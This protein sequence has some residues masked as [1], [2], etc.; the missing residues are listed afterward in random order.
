MGVLLWLFS[1][2]VISLWIFSL[3]CYIW[4]VILRVFAWDAFILFSLVCV[5]LRVF[6]SGCSLACVIIGVVLVCLSSLW[7]SLC[8]CSLILVVLLCVLSWDVIFVG[9]LFMVFSC[10]CYRCGCSL[11]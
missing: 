2:W 5:I 9:V 6:Y 3:W 8:G 4:G 1:V 7:C 10:V 11:C